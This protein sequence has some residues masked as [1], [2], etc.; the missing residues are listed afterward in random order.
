MSLSKVSGD[1][2]R[3][4]W[5]CLIS[6]CLKSTRTRMRCKHF[7]TSFGLMT[8]VFRMVSSSS[9]VANIDAMKDSSS[10]SPSLARSTDIFESKLDDDNDQDDN[11]DDN[12][13]AKDEDE[14]SYVPSLSESW[15]LTSMFCRCVEKSSLMLCRTSLIKSCRS[16]VEGIFLLYQT[17]CKFKYTVMQRQHGFFDIINM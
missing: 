17:T 14:E 8:R 9:G 3:L 12:D 13:E 4:C 15:S 6:F 11:E 10:L 5:K 16:D 1:T 7:S 2:C